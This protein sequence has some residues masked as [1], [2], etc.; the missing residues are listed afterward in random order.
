MDNRKAVIILNKNEI[1]LNRLKSIIGDELFRAVCDNLAGLQIY[2]KPYSL[3]SNMVER[4]NHIKEDR[5]SGADWDELT[6]KYRLSESRIKDIF[7][8]RENA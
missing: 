4:N 5:L 6:K 3:Y 2:I 7:Y 1:A 8:D